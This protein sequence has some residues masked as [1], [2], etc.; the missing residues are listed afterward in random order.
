MIVVEQDIASAD[1][2]VCNLGQF[3]QKPGFWGFSLHCVQR[4]SGHSSTNVLAA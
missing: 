3:V 4:P 2:N 1:F